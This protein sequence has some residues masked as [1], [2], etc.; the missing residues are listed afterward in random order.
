MTGAG[1][2]KRLVAAVGENTPIVYNT[3][4]PK[5]DAVDAA[6]LEALGVRL[7][8]FPG[9]ALQSAAAGMIASLQKLK[10]DPS[11]TG[12]A[13]TPMP[14]RELLELLEAAPFIE[15]FEKS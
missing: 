6:G 14:G 15:K 8:L 13:Q 3:I 7:A 11:L 4:Y 12:G 2:L 5:G 9:L 1:D 10:V